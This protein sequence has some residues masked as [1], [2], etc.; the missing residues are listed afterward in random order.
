MGKQVDKPTAGPE[1]VEINRAPVLTLWAAVV[2]ERLGYDR[3]T[4]LT[5]AKAVAG[6]DAQ[7]KGQRLG[8]YE[9]KETEEK[10][11][12][13]KEKAKEEK[14]G[15]IVEL[16]G[17]AIPVVKTKEGVR[18]TVKDK[19]VS[20]ES[21]ERYLSSK[22]GDALPEV[23]QS[24]EELARAYRPKELARR[25]YRLYTEFRPEIPAGVKGW[26]AKGQL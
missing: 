22:F 18:A 4:A 8:I 24:M 15:P 26:G 23:R 17:R 7:A 10:E 9:P 2:A 13:K 5:L 11:K 3:D 12:A 19:A 6:L 1:R 14:E 20:P 25:A 21:V 16:L